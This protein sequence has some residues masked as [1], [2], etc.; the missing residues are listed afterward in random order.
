MLHQQRLAILGLGKI[1]GTLAG[2]LL[3]QGVI[4]PEQ[5]RGTTGH[6]Q[7]AQAAGA[8]YGITVDC[9]NAGAVRASDL[10]ILAVKPQRMPAILAEI[11]PAV[12]P[13]QLFITI[14]AAIQTGYVEQQLGQEISV[15]RGMPNMPCLV[16]AGMTVLCPGRRVG[17]EQLTLARQIFAAVGRVALL[18]REELMDAVTGLSGSGPAYAYVIIEA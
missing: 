15:I 3:E 12:R 13:E 11:R 7:S 8:R 10:I 18:D 9:D 16:Q 5:L 14:A 4:A 2:A 1:G 6:P 17:Q